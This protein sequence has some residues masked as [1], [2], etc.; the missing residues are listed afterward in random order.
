MYRYG[1]VETLT[2]IYNGWFTLPIMCAMVSMV[3]QSFFAWRIY[4]LSK[5][6][7]LAGGI[8]FVSSLTESVVCLY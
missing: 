8:V 7:M 1:D 6:R 3:V 4:M 5:V 2:S